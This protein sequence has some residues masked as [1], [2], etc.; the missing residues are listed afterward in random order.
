M[1]EDRK[2]ILSILQYGEKRQQEI[3]ELIN[4]SGRVVR[5]KLDDLEQTG[6]ISKEKR[7][8]GT[9]YSLPDSD[10]I[11]CPKPPADDVQ[12]ER[13]LHRSA[14]GIELVSG[15]NL[16]GTD[17]ER[18]NKI[19]EGN[20]I[21]IYDTPLALCGLMELSSHRY[22][23][24]SDRDNRD[25]YFEIFDVLLEKDGLATSPRKSI[26]ANRGVPRSEIEPIL[27]PLVKVT[28]DEIVERNPFLSIR[29]DKH[30]IKRVI[31]DPEE[32]R[33]L[34]GLTYAAFLE[35][36]KN[37]YENYQRG[38]ENDEIRERFLNRTEKMKRFVPP[39]IS[40]HE[41]STAE[42]LLGSSENVS[43]YRT[44]QLSMDNLLKWVDNEAHKELLRNNIATGNFDEEAMSVRL[45][46]AYDQNNEIHEL[47]NSLDELKTNASKPVQRKIERLQN[48]VER[49]YKT[50]CR[51]SSRGIRFQTEW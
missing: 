11:V 17:R 6:K 30:V 42:E 5:K 28:P 22:Y 2:N 34:P 32:T 10:K 50:E 4:R 44:V 1:D 51:S 15:E 49:R 48:A 18:N 45:F 29:V 40:H 14:L 37:V 19:A 23:V 31:E 21:Q 16:V 39:D 3:I 47:Q 9:Y 26:L 36:A 24:L 38:K 27:H 7:G 13:L 46:E 25:L 43:P 20:G 33:Y 12:V 35:T 8:G 41:Q